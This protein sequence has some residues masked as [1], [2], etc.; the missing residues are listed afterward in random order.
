MVKL[1][2]CI[3]RSIE[4]GITKPDNPYCQKLANGFGSCAERRI[5]KIAEN[6]KALTFK[7]R[8]KVEAQEIVM[9]C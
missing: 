8:M 6:W 5:S 3:E 2:N 4:I 7:G 9:L 1:L